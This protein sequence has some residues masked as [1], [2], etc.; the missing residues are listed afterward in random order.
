MSRTVLLATS[1][2]PVTHAKVTAL[3]DAV[4]WPRPRLLRYVLP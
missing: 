1:L 3:A 2:D 4:Q